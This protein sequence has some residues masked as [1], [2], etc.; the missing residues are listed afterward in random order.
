MSAI[1][2]GGE[3]IEILIPPVV[4]EPVISIRIPS[5]RVFTLED[6]LY[7]DLNTKRQLIK[8]VQSRKTLLISG[9]TGSGKTSF[10]SALSAYLPEGDRI[11][12]IEDPRELNLPRDRHPDQVRMVFNRDKP[13]QTAQALFMAC[14]RHNPDMVSLAECRGAEALDFLSAANS[15]HYGMTTVHADSPRKAIDKM[16]T[17][18]GQGETAMTHENL[19]DYL[20]S[21]IDGV[22]QITFDRTGGNRVVSGVLLLGENHDI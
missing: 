12:T 10:M 15:G 18:A 8:L 9:G 20:K 3:R 19:V 17:L 5:D 16:A 14:M 13:N 7:E 1:L 22:V 6:F 2:F 4:E 11:V 21:I